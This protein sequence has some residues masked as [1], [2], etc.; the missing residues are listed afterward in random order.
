MVTT[1][2]SIAILLGG[3]LALFSLAFLAFAGDLFGLFFLPRGAFI[4]ALGL[5]AIRRWG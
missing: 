2:G 5:V 1:V 3:G 4:A